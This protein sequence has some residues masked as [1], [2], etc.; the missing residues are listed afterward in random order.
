MMSRGFSIRRPVLA[1]TLALSA[2]AYLPRAAEAAGIRVIPSETR[3][4]PGEDFTLDIVA[5]NIPVDD[6]LGAVQFRLHVAAPGGK[7]EGIPDLGQAA[8]DAVSVASPLLIS[9]P[10]ATRSGLGDFFLG[11]YQ[12][13][14]GILMLD[15]EPLQNGS[16][17][18]TYAHTSGANLPNGSGTVARFRVR[19]GSHVTAEQIHISLSDV[20]LLDGGAVYSLDTN[21]GATITL[22]CTATV[23]NLSGLSLAEAQ[24]AINTAG[25]TLGGIYEIN[26]PGNSRP[27]GVVLEQS[28]TSGTV[29]DCE[30][31]VNL[32]INAAP[33]EASGL[34]IADK[35]GDDTGTVLLSWSP[36]ASGDVAGYRIYRQGI[37]LLEVAAPQATGAEIGGLAHGVSHNLVVKTYDTH[38]NES[39]G[40]S[41][42]AT[43]LDDVY[44]VV[45]ISGVA[46]GVFYK[47]PVQPQVSATDTNLNGWTALLG[48]TTYDFTPVTADGS[49]TLTVTARDLSGNVTSESVFFTIDGTAP[50]ISVADLIDG[51]HYHRDLVPAIVINDT[52][53]LDDLTTLNLDGQP[54]VS[55]T[56]ITTEGPH[57]LA[58]SARDRA[59]NIG[60]LTLNFVIDK[61]APVI[62]VL[63]VADNAFYNVD[64]VPQVTI[65]DLYIE[66]SVI[67]LN[68]QPYLSGTALGGEGEYLLSIS[69]RDRAGNQAAQTVRFVIDK[70]APTITVEGVTDEAFYKVDVLPTVSVQDVYLKTSSI[71][72]N[73]QPFVPGTELTAEGEYR[74]VMTVEDQAGNQAAQ[75][76]R[77]FIDKTAPVITMAGVADGVFY[78]A[79][80]TPV[81]GI[82]DAYLQ[83]S[84]LTLNGQLFTSGTP[85]V[86]EGSYTLAAQAED[87]AGNLTERSVS[88][89]IDKT[90]PTS[91]SSIG[92]P[93]FIAGEILYVA[94]QTAVTLT[95]ID[96]GL[97][98]TGLA[99]LEYALDQTEEWATYALPITLGH[100]ED[101]AH[102][103]NYRSDDR[104]GNREELQTFVAVLDKT[105]PQTTVVRDGAAFD[106][107]EGILF[108]TAETTFN[109]MA[110][111]SLSGVDSTRY[112]LDG[113]PWNEYAPFRLAGLPDGEHTVGY[114]SGDRVANQ[115]LEQSLAVI[116]DNTAPVTTITVGEPQFTTDGMKYVTRSTFFTLTAADNLTGVAA[117]EYRLDD[118]QWQVYTAP[119]T[120]V[121]LPDGVHVI[122]YRSMDK[123]GNA[124]GEQIL[125]IAVDKLA[126]VST[127]TVDYPQY[128]TDETLYVG[129]ETLFSLTVEDA[130]S[131]VAATEYRFDGGPW[132]AYAPFHLL[133][134]GEHLIEYRSM[135]N[136]GNREELRTL[137]VITDATPP[138]SDISF[139]NRSFTAGEVVLVTADTEVSFNAN[140][141][142]SGVKVI[143]YRFDEELAWHEY[144]GSIRLTEL[145]YGTH[146]LHYRSIDYVDNEE[147]EKA[148]TLVRIGIEVDSEIL[149]LPR[150]LVWT[151]DPD[152]ITGK[153]QPAY[154]LADIQALTS[155]ALGHPDIYFHLVND[156]D[157]FQSEFRSGIY[158]TIM[159]LDEDLPFDTVFLREM[160]EA[161]HRGTG[162][163]ISNW[164]NNVPPILQEVF[165]IDFSGSL[166]TSEEERPLVLFP[167]PLAEGQ[168]LT[169]NGRVLRTRIAG[170]TLAGIVPAESTCSGLRG[171]ALDYPIELNAGDRV[172]VSLS[173]PQGKN[174]TL[175]EEE[176]L[177]VEGLPAGPIN[178][179]TG[180]TVGDL[181]ISGM[182][183]QGFSPSISAPYGYLGDR[184]V[185]AVTVE[186]T[187]G[188]RI[189]TGPVFITPTCGANL[190]AGMV[191][192]PFNLKSVNED[193]VRSGED[194]PAVVLGMYGRGQTIFFAYDILGSA[195][196]SNRAEHLSVLR[197]AASHLL[198]ETAALQSGGIALL[199]TKV[200]LEGSAFD[201]K[202]V[203]KLDDGLTHL[204]LFSL[205]HDPLEFAFRLAESGEASYRYFVRAVDRTGAYGKETEVLLGL[206][207]DYTLFDR[208]TFAWAI[209]CDSVSLVQQAILWVEEQLR[210]HPEA[211]QE[212]TAIGETLNVVSCMPR[213][214]KAEVEKVIHQIVQTIQQ[215][216][217][218]PLDAMSLR[219]ALGEYLRI[220]EGEG[221]ILR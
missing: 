139:N 29:V 114:F 164:G 157:E 101:G 196:S 24:S 81:V 215:T 159:I 60:N 107:A 84:A 208:Y 73:E 183:A 160:R 90:A 40:T 42:A 129:I 66:E 163:L 198:P 146:L 99:T 131:G 169:V 80:V 153:D 221:Y 193:R 109:L 55:G 100:L 210:Q 203:E 130:L 171:L 44:P 52:N 74:L 78:N 161:V 218:L 61:T 145:A 21:Q 147:A 158:N 76:I 187:D 178:R 89:V 112:R 70:T 27:L 192:G 31:A 4:A 182:S 71:T 57:I 136:L 154:T 45:I 122:A 18:Y 214:T 63:G 9:T 127:L 91:S 16:A 47:E 8:L 128:R 180:N 26:N 132:L 197:M 126:P 98:P 7:V 113:G 77:F 35:A 120:L 39:P 138:E 43:P 175:I 106:G 110:A 168:A 65:A 173:V 17:L 46:D 49:Y 105:P 207:G 25:L 189:V 216:G 86:A 13:N 85:V 87:R 33:S 151:R 34:T 184:Y 23:P 28:I 133:A 69:A 205:T 194:V 220:V 144:H 191:L 179:F 20:M 88:F 212:L 58:I 59:G 50:V 152:R 141:R 108:I 186:R 64:V 124:E 11:S 103:V 94:A 79:D 36:S 72:L 190:Q 54:Y 119:F 111:D 83:A 104:A 167:S 92:E 202:A 199:E 156:K 82:E 176:Q 217:Q 181:A 118:G 41:I 135:D 204:P 142:L 51:A 155:E 48:N 30:A 206:D 12:G 38:G 185:I 165:G 174:L 67:L 10:T 162:L 211:T 200:R 14:S 172:T 95:A 117:T 68:G 75:T 148:V 123:V 150:V 213:T 15:N 134:E 137:S 37:L 2:L 201:L 3:V 177:T 121:D 53:L 143:Q 19:V 188:N 97:E 125:T 140:D 56:S 219:G 32:A 93:R 1:C 96:G 6:G 116:V 115:E 209:D 102:R 62:T 166:A 195:I 149:N 5:E 170:G 22:R